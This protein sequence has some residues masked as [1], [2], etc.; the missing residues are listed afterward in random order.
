VQP[1]FETIVQSAVSLCGSPY[2]NVFR[3]DGEL[4]HFAAFHNLRCPQRACRD[5][6]IGGIM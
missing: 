4:L 6:K 2:A 1:V 5:G 3:F